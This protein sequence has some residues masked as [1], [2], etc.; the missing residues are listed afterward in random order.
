MTLLHSDSRGVQSHQVTHNVALVGVLMPTKHRM[1]EASACIVI[2]AAEF[3][4]SG[5]MCQ[6]PTRRVWGS[7][8][9]MLTK[10]AGQQD[11]RYLLLP[12]AAAV[13]AG[14][15]SVTL[16]LLLSNCHQQ[17]LFSLQGTSMAQR[18]SGQSSVDQC[19]YCYHQSA[20]S[21][22]H[23]S[24]TVHYPPH[25]ERRTAVESVA[26]CWQWLLINWSSSSSICQW[27]TRRT[28]T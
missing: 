6:C 12:A 14:L 22:L 28:D 18:S 13:S 9:V 17:S 25:Q 11:R 16:P 3:H 15:V 26:C 2:A 10:T 23:Q 7:S 24:A 4:R 27:L 19:K 5:Q 1:I 20:A 21:L 8:A